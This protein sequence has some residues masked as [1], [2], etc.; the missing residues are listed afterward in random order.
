[1]IWRDRVG[2]EPTEDV[3]RLPSGFE[4]QGEHQFLIRPQFNKRIKKFIYLLYIY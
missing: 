1:M 4:D 3:T 2:I